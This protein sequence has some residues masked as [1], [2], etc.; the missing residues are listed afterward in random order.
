MREDIVDLPI[1]PIMA[2][3]AKVSSGAGGAVFE[4][5]PHLTDWLPELPVSIE[6]GRISNRLVH[7]RN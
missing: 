7:S 3:A 6:L 2:Y 4:D 5:V 1:P